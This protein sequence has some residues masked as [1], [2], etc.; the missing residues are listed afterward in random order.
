MSHREI[1]I[2]TLFYD[3]ERETDL[4]GRLRHVLTNEERTFKSLQELPH[5]LSQFTQGRVMYREEK[6]ESS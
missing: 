6:K 2:V 5:L 1:F 4:P 3:P